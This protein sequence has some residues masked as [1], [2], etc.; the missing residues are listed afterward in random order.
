MFFL[1]LDVSAHPRNLRLAHR[2]RAISFLPRKRATFLE[3]SRNPAGGVSFYFTDKFRERF[4]LPQFRQDVN[5]VR[6]SVYGQRDSAFVPNRSAEVF[7]NPRAIRH[8]HQRFAVLRG[9]H[10]VI[11]QIAM[12][13]THSERPFRR[14]LSGAS[15]S[16]DD[17][18][19]VPLRSTPSCSSA[20]LHC[21]GVP[22][23]ST[24]RF[25][26][27]HPSGALQRR[28]RAGLKP[29]VERSGTRG[30][31]GIYI[32]KTPDTGWRKAGR[33]LAAVQLT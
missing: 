27:P 17:I 16:S 2:E 33:N 25:I 23:R 28:R 31:G 6:G 20:A 4:V 8:R 19:G 10:N 13:G 7:V 1:P 24:P 26:P 22:L 5:V 9:K 11:Q 21:P 32:F 14:P 15:L 29:R 3:R 18:P 30:T 12:G